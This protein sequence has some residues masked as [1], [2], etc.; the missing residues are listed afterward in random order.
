MYRQ[1]GRGEEPCPLPLLASHSEN[2]KG[3]PQESSCIL[4]LH[5]VV[6][7][8][9]GCAFGRDFIGV[10]GDAQKKKGECCDGHSKRAGQEESI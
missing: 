3:Q 7:R 2:V 1:K 10:G 4:H 6:L 8:F 9:C 5:G